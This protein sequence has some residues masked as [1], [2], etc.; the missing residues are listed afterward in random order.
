MHFLCFK[1]FTI[2]KISVY[3]RWFYFILFSMW[4]QTFGP[5][6]YYFYYQKLCVH[7]DHNA[8]HKSQFMSHVAYLKIIMRVDGQWDGHQTTILR[9]MTDVNWPKVQYLVGKK[10]SA[11]FC[12]HGQKGI[13]NLRW[14]FISCIIIIIKQWSLILLW[15]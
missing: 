11:T 7:L 13:K 5:H 14:T 3:I 4:Y 2:L 10:H 1:N 8:L 12:T 15:I 9:E 6:W